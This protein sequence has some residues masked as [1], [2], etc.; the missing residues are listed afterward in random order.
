MAWSVILTSA[1]VSAI[2]SSGMALLGQRIERKARREELIFSRAVEVSLA[3]ARAAN[4][5]SVA[6]GEK[7]I[8]RPILAMAADVHKELRLLLETGG[9]SKGYRQAEVADARERLP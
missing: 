7:P 9:I 1:V 5:V 6:N 3:R 8:D 4:E 2:V